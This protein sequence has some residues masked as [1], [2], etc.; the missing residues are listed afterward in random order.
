MRLALRTL[1]W[2]VLAAAVAIGWGVEHWRSAAKLGETK[3]QGDWF[4]MSEAST[5]PSEDALARRAKLAE[6]TQLSDAELR[7]GLGIR[8]TSLDS[9]Q[10]GNVDLVELEA[11]FGVPIVR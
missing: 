4:F 11:G 1:F 7:R 9:N 8:F 2:L 10:D 5:G 3:K 6:L